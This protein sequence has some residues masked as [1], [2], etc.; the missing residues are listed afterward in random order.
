MSKPP[1]LVPPGGED[2]TRPS[3]IKNVKVNVKVNVFDGIDDDAY[4]IKNIS[5][6][7]PK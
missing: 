7:S 3:S 6:H 1:R 4:H 5:K 2:W